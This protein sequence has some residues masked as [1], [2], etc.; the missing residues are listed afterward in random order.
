MKK[1]REKKNT[2]KQNAILHQLHPSLDVGHGHA[3]H[4][5]CEGCYVGMYLLTS[6]G[7][8][9]SPCYVQK[10]EK[11]QR[12][13]SLNCA[14]FFLGARTVPFLTWKM[15]FGFFSPLACRKCFCL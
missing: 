9:N 14:N 3:H 13:R 10:Q 4:G 15:L 6:T 12:A 8:S 5:Y 11:G 1:Q 2:N 7:S